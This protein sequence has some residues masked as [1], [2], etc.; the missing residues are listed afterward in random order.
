MTADQGSPSLLILLDLSAAFDTVDH[1]ILL[2]RLQT[3]VGLS[4]ITLSWFQSYLTGRTEHVA[5]GQAKSLPH[6][7]TCGVPQGSVLGPTLFTIYMLP[8]GEIVR[9]H[10]L[11]FHC[12]A[13]DTQ[14]YLKM[15]SKSTSPLP[16]ALNTCLEEI[17]AWMAN[18]FL[19][20]NTNKTE[21]ILIGTPH[22]T[23]SSP[24]TSI[25]VCGHNILLSPSVTNLGVKLDSHLSFDN[26]IRRLSKVSFLHLKNIAKLRP[27]L[28]QPDA[29]K[30]IHAFISSRLD[31]C[32]A[33]L[34]GISGRS[35]Q[36]L[37]HI[38]NCAARVLTRKRKYDHITPVLRSLHWLPIPYRIQYKL[39]LL[40][41]HCLHET[42]PAYLSELL[43]PHTTSR[44]LRSASSHFLH[45]PR[46]KLSTMG[47]RAFQAAAPRLWNALPK[48]L[49]APQDVEI[50]KKG[51]KTFFFKKAY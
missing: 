47:G 10:G 32:N 31:Y 42:A 49:R 1:Q 12:Y 14:L 39:C 26:H 25:N 51:L 38:Q 17:R 19:Q 4:D 36:K 16:S 6:T 30:L 33:L 23:Q 35:L 11:S 18:N 43:N 2:N 41:Y 44:C 5:L 50:F 45:Q 48:S 13:D 46:T 40:T 15:D 8:L 21:A 22:Q 3:V 34:I 20:L 24:I 29:E 27:S 7:V 9:K 28:S 37:Q